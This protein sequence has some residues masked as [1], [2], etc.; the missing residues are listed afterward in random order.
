MPKGDRRG[1]NGMGPMTGRGA[2]FCNG[3]STPGFINSGFAGGYGLGRGA[4]RGRGFDRSYGVGF[5]R[6][7][8]RGLGMGYQAYS[9]APEYLKDNEK[10]Y[11]ENEVSYLKDQLKTLENRLSEIKEEE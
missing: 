4:G 2:G 9:A 11:L 1:P 3:S 6:G 10:G 7:M 8:G 5:G